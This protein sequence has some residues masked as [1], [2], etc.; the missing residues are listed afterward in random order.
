MHIAN[1][2]HPPHDYRCDARSGLAPNHYE[3]D[4]MIEIE[5]N[6]GGNLYFVGQVAWVQFADGEIFMVSGR[7]YARPD[8]RRS[9]W[10]RGC[11]L[12]E[13]DFGSA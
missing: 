11:I 5:N 12:Y 2:N 8:G 13:Q 6:Y 9:S 7:Q 3:E 10:L 4:R 1:P